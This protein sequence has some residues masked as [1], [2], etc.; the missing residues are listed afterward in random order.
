MDVEQLEDPQSLW[1]ALD[2]MT[3]KPTRFWH[4]TYPDY[5]SDYS[6]TYIN[7]SL[8]HPFGL[9]AVDCDVCGEIWGGSRFLPVALPQRLRR[10]PAMADN[11]PVLSRKEHEELQRKVMGILGM[12]GKPF[13]AMQPGDQFQPCFLDVPSRPSADFLW[14][15]IGSLVVSERVKRL[16][17]AACPKEIAACK[18]TMRRIGKRSPHLEPIEPDSGE[19]EDMLEGIK[20]SG[21]P[22]GVGK[23]FE[24]ILKKESGDPPYGAP[25]RICSGCQ[26]PTTGEDRRMR[27]TPRMW[28]G[29]AIFF[30]ATTLHVIVTDDLRQSIERLRP[31]NVRFEKPDIRPLWGE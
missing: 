7:G 27:M 26:R 14:S 22:R 12:R 1:V 21:R 11:P 17:E 25:K 15:S 5:D 4:L 28:R 16:F 23:Y 24:I 18:V 8:E 6:H 29:D 3:R 30:M 2:C 10:L 9:P 13:V 19:P 31:T 20:E